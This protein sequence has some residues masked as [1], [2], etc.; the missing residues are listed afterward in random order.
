MAKS[1]SAEL[2]K[3]PGLEMLDGGE[4]SVMIIE[5]NWLA[6]KGTGNLTHT[7]LQTMSYIKK[8]LHKSWWYVSPPKKEEHNTVKSTHA[9]VEIM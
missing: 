4:P 7:Y 8:V 1:P 9:Y 5:S 3:Q 6:F 2:A